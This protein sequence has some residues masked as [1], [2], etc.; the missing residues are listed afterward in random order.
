MSG[1]VVMKVVTAFKEFEAFWTFVLA[2]SLV[3]SF[4]M[5]F[6][7][8]GATEHFTAASQGTNLLHYYQATDQRTHWPK[9]Q[10]SDSSLRLA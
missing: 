5:S 10:A 4:D 8:V 9:W 6:E 3:V 7:T 1:H 2:D